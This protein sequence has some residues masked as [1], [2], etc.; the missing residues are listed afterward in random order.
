MKKYTKSAFTLVELI[1][2]ITILAILATVAFISLAG[3][4]Q[5]AKNSKVVSDLRTII[6]AIETKVTEGKV[7]MSEISDGTLATNTV[8]GEYASGST[9]GTDW[10]YSVWKINFLA[11]RVNSSDFNYTDG[12]L[13]REY[14]AASAVLDNDNAFYQVAWEIKNADN[15]YTAVVKGNYLKIGNNDVDGIIAV[16]DNSGSWV[17]NKATLASTLHLY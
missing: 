16:S 14:V 9:L 2:V 12:E 11:L 8:S 7:T 13:T 6:T 5:Q 1:V 3:K 10:T 17:L 15:S 4:T